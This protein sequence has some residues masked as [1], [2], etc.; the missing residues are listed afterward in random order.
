[1]TRNAHLD[2]LPSSAT[3]SVLTI[4]RPVSKLQDQ[5]L[6]LLPLLITLGSMSWDKDRTDSFI[7]YVL[8]PFLPALLASTLVW[9]TFRSAISLSLQ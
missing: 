4:R 6:L 8:E 5:T 2:Y 9:S 3:P 7:E 1:M